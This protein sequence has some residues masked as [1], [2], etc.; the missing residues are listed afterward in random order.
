MNLADLY[1]PREGDEFIPWKENDQ[2]QYVGFTVLRDYPL[3]SSFVPVLTKEGKQDTK[4]MIRLGH[5]K[6]APDGN[7]IKLYATATKFSKYLS[8]HFRYD[9]DDDTNSP[10]KESIDQSTKSSQPVDLE[11]NDRYLL[12]PA[13]SKVTDTRN[14]KIVTISQI[15]DDLYNQHIQT[16]DGPHAVYFKTK[17]KAKSLLFSVP[18][19]LK[20]KLIWINDF[21]FGKILAQPSDFRKGFFE[22]YDYKDLISVYPQS[23]PFFNSELKISKKCILWVAITLLIFWY[24]LRLHNNFREMNDVYTIAVAVLF[25]AFYDTIIPNFILFVTNQTIRMSA[26]AA[27]SKFVQKTRF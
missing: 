3:S 25:T 13:T 4:V 5:S 10:T 6:T 9:F 12:D 18:Y 24:W 1:K 2:S 27:S 22:P 17:I 21:L 19:G 14:G 16:I 7:Q 8:E 20:P 15:I 11:E 23:V 26:W